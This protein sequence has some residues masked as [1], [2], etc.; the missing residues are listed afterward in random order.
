VLELED[1]ALHVDRDLARE[2][3]ACHCGGYL[4][5]VA[6][7]AGEVARHRVD[8]VGEIFPRA[9]HARHVGLA[10]KLA[11]RSYV[12]RDARYFA[13]RAAELIDHRVEGLFQLQDFAAHV[14]GDLAREIATRDRGG[15]LG[16]VA[17]L[18][19]KIARHR[20]DAVG[21]VLPRSGDAGNG[22]LATKLAVGAHLARH[23]RYFRGEGVEL[24]DHGVHRLLQDQ[25]LATDVDSDLL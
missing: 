20:V 18:I 17:H 12:R 16:D 11:F 23:A 22:R 24:I 10:T 3:S 13:G 4:G 9:G 25:D 21:Q 14:D 7:L 6:H 1:L 8:A 19:G 2:V 5:D 15:N